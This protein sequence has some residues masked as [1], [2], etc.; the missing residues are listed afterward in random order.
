[1]LLKNNKR[2]SLEIEEEMK[3][4]E[5]MVQVVV[6]VGAARPDIWSYMSNLRIWRGNVN[7]SLSR[8]RIELNS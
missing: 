1:M 7:R 3:E 2:S 5:I 6:M 8:R 4:S